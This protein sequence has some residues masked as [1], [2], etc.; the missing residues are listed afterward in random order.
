MGSRSTVTR[1]KSLKPRMQAP[2]APLGFRWGTLNTV[3]LLAGVL[4]LFAG[5]LSLS[6]GSITLAPA[7]LVAGYCVLLPASLLVRGGGS[8]PGE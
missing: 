7:L 6:R 1:P 4:A 3:I 8:E 5:Y 2:E